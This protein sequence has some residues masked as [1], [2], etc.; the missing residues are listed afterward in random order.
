[1]SYCSCMQLLVFPPPPAPFPPSLPPFELCFHFPGPLVF[2][3]FLFND[4]FLQILLSDGLVV[5]CCI[6]YPCSHP[7][8]SEDTAG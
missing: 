2:V 8:A 5:V 3:M 7:Y 6:Y 1:M 4:T